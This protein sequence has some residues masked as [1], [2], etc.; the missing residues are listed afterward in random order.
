MS[1]KND[2]QSHNCMLEI[3]ERGSTVL[4]EEAL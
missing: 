4:R 2:S 3:S 1:H